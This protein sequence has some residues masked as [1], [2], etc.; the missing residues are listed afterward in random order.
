MWTNQVLLN[1][2][3]PLWLVERTDAP[4]VLLAWLFGTNTV[5][6]I[7]LPPYMS[8]MVTDLRSALRNIGIAT[9]FFVVSCLI[10][11][12]THSTVGFVTV[13]LVWLGHVT[14]TGAELFLSAANWTF[15]ADLMDPRRRG[16]YQGVGEVFSKAGFLWAP[17]VYTYLAMQWG[18]VGWLVIAAI[19]VVAAIGLRWS[20]VMAD[21]FARRHFPVANPASSA[22]S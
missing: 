13:A 2:V 17:A 1:I 18:D 14:V 4:H 8:R 3:I 16:E 21:R 11:M 15:Q 6:C 19:V 7:F 20:A 12:A 9:A 22:V 5:L 10:T